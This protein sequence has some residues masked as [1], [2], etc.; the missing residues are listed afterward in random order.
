M[1]KNIIVSIH[2]LHTCITHILQSWCEQAK[3]KLSY[4]KN[5]P[6]LIVMNVVLI[7]W[8]IYLKGTHIGYLNLEQIHTFLKYSVH[9]RI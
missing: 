5:L 7:I 9:A 1:N 3:L 8:V 4:Q 2:E 6:D